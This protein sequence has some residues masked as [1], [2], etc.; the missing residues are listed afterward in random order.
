MAELPG[1]IEALESEQA[2][3]HARIES[4][5][6]YKDPPDAITQA[7]ARADE[8]KDALH[9]AYTRWDELDSR[10]Q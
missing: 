8:L 4:P 1:R 5:H 7:L 9:E 3:L 10:S 6:F 2:A